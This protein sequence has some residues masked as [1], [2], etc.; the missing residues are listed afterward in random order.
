MNPYSS[1]LSGLNDGNQE[2]VDAKPPGLSAGTI[3]ATIFMLLFGFAGLMGIIG[4]IGNAVMLAG[5]NNMMQVPVQTAPDGSTDPSEE[6]SDMDAEGQGD[7][8]T[9]TGTKVV[10]PAMIKPSFANT[11]STLAL[12]IFDFIVAIP[13]VLWSIQILQRK[14]SAAVKLSWLALGM[15]L[16]TIVRGILGYIFLPEA[17]EQA[18]QGM[19]A[20]QQ[21]QRPGGAPPPPVDAD[22]LIQIMTSVGFGCMGILFLFSFLVYLFTF[23]QLRK[24]STL[25]RLDR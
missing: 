9:G 8:Q 14:Q 4:L 20:A 23:F 6:T 7:P 13:M 19:L 17:L 25:E 11:V 3:I 10:M 16:M 2:R 24:P 15:A 1:E 5:G 21:Q 18:K 12:G 22:L